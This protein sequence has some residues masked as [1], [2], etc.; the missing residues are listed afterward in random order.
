MN[1]EAQHR[2]QY[3]VG[4]GVPEMDNQFWEPPICVLSAFL[5]EA[6]IEALPHVTSVWAAI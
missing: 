3:I 2:P 5:G 1:W 4:P 6:E